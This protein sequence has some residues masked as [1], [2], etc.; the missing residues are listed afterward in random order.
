MLYVD[1]KT[2][3]GRSTLYYPVRISSFTQAQSMAFPTRRK[4][5]LPATTPRNVFRCTPEH[6]HEAITSR[7]RHMSR[8]FTHH[9]GLPVWAEEARERAPVVAFSMNQA[10]GWGCARAVL[11]ISGL[12]QPRN[13]LEF[14]NLG[15]SCTVV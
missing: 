14:V 13:R 2:R 12:V 4:Q 1:P 11:C 9:L 10:S 8:K 6:E 15:N 7:M 3:R 5:R